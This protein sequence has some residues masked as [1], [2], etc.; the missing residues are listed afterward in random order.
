MQR[1][2]GP[3]CNIPFCNT[4]RAMRMGTL[5]AATWLLAGCSILP[6][7][8]G[9]T[10]NPEP[11]PTT[12]VAPTPAPVAAAPAPEPAP[13]PVVTPITPPSPVVLKA[14][15]E[16]PPPPPKPVVEPS[17]PVAP[18]AMVA[19]Y[20]INVGLFAVP[21]NGQKAFKTLEQAGMPVFSDGVVSKTKGA[22]TR[23]RVGPYPK[24]ADAD[25]AAKKIRSLKLDAVVFKH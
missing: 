2:L 10:P 20:Y 14:P 12:E 6:T 13:A 5:A 8:L 16:P 22:L 9:G 25:A 11:Q 7:W 3:F 17:K 1:P 21:A 18:A 15:E 19:G 23:V 24:R 4:R